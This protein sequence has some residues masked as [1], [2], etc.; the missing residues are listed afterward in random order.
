[1][2]QYGS[3][4]LSMV[5]Y[6][7]VWVKHTKCIALNM[8]TFG[9]QVRSVYVRCSSGP[10]A[11]EMDTAESKG[12]RTYKVRRTVHCHPTARVPAQVPVGPAI[13]HVSHP[14]FLTLAEI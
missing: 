1:M 2:A 11:T 13:A 9:K 7:S 6:D 12:D 14:R 5:Q 4:W 3:V 8:V 10:W